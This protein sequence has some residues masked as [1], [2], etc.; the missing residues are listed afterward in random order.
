MFEIEIKHNDLFND[1]L[2]RTIVHKDSVYDFTFENRY[3]IYHINKKTVVSYMAV[4]MFTNE[5]YKITSVI[6]AEQYNENSFHML[7]PDVLRS[8]NRSSSETYIALM[9]DNIISPIELINAIFRVVLHNSGYNIRESQIRLSIDIFNGFTQKQVSICEAGVGSGKTLAYLVAGI[10]ARYHYKQK[11]QIS[12]PLTISTSSIELQKTLVNKEIPNLSRL[13]MKYYIIP[14]P[15]DAV[16][17][18][19]KE[20]YICL[21]R[22][23]DYVSKVEK[24][25]EK[26]SK[27]LSSLY[28]MKGFP[29]GVDLDNYSLN[30]SV[31]KKINNRGG[32]DSCPYTRLCEYVAMNKTF[33][34]NDLDIQVTNHNLYLASQKA[35][36]YAITSVLLPSAFVVIDEAHKF[37]EAAQEVFCLSLSMSDVLEYISCSKNR[38]SEKENMS[39]YKSHISRVVNKSKV[40][41]DIVNEK[42]NVDNTDNR[43]GFLRLDYNIQKIIENIIYHINKIEDMKA[44]YERRKMFQCVSLLDTLNQLLTPN[45]L[46]WVDTDQNDR[47]I[48]N[49]AP[50]NVAQMIYEKVWNQNISHV[51]TSGTMSDGN[52][53]D[54]FKFENGIDCVADYLVLESNTKSP[55][56]Y[57]TNTRLYIPHNLPRLDDSNYIKEISRLCLEIIEV[58]NGHTM[59]LFTSYSTLNSVYSDLKEKLRHYEIIKTSKGYKNTIND[60]N[61]AKNAVLFA[62][63]SMWEGVN[64]V[65][66]KLSSVIVVRLPFPRSSVLMEAKRK[67]FDDL[68]SYIERYCIPDMLIKLRQGVG[69]LI[70]SET[71]TG[72][73]TILD[74]RMKYNNH[75]RDRVL[76][77]LAD[78]TKTDDINEVRSFFEKVKP[79]GYWVK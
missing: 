30:R 5:S 8:I 37:K 45:K 38:C 78:Y 65:G 41:F 49:C 74:E 51:L 61:K 24:F 9:G 73:I 66:D 3:L 71:D 36:E 52:G 79:T 54:Y 29:Q 59:I 17:R 76:N 20:N 42:M 11:Y 43:D 35:K 12:L 67:S 28:E 10:V 33:V 39:K 21:R 26:Y 1:F 6:S 69:R 22:F 64:I 50:V 70:R 63:G 32:C 58:T 55:F 62:L 40:L 60:F 31:K 14:K 25:P 4:D 44:L 47:V 56:N 53:F 18:K 19:G 34:N 68:H 13:L 27:T 46:M 57:K 77:T 72:V 23:D 75:Y 15:I 48:I 7:I 2:Y 16:L